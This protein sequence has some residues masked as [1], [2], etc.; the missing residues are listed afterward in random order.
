MDK[1][2]NKGKRLSVNAS[3]PDLGK[4]PPQCIDIE[5]VILGAVMI[6][7][8]NQGKVMH[9]LEPEYFY[10]EA[11]QNIVIAMKALIKRNE[12]IDILTITNE[13]KATR[14]LESV[15]GPYF[16]TSLTNRIASAANIEVHVK[17][18]K[19]NFIARHLIATS[20][21]IIKQAF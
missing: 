3:E 13:L 15:G 17:I 8:L 9:L 4:L 2:N 20:S 18:L 1:N 14:K 11:H 21:N 10:K 7:K 6:E 16:I 5:E 12:S 19:Q